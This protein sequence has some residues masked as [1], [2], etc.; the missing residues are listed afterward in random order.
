MWVVAFCYLF[1]THREMMLLITS[2]LSG[3]AHVSL[4][5]A[6][7]YGV[8]GVGSDSSDVRGSKGPIVSV[9][10]TERA[11]DAAVKVIF[12]FCRS[13]EVGGAK[14]SYIATRN[15]SFYGLT[16][17]KFKGYVRGNCRCWF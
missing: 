13:W 16:C 8:L 5:T 17:S 9:V 6:T 2:V 7:I 11:K 1:C 3:C 12:P 15:E 14:A 10:F 4:S